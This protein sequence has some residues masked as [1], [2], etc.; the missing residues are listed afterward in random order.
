M[1]GARYDVQS[2]DPGPIPLPI[3]VIHG[4]EDQL[5]PPTIGDWLHE[6]ARDSRSL[7]VEGG[8]HMLPIT[9][10]NLLADRIAPFVRGG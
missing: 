6:H 2:L 1:E 3:L 7:R 10:T 8:S 5:A 9:H 4:D